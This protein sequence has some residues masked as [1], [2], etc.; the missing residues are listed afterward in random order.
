[1]RLESSLVGLVLLRLVSNQSI[2]T[3]LLRARLIV[4]IY[5]RTNY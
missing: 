1:M 3:L 5:I 2:F 4:S